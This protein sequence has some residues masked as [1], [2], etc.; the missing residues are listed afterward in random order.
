MTLKIL[1]I[2]IILFLSRNAYN[3]FNDTRAR[4]L[5]YFCGMTFTYLKLHFGCENVNI[6]S[7]FTHCYNGRHY[8]TLHD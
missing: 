2:I 6:L 7:S 8:V 5:D 4:L 3:K 1:A